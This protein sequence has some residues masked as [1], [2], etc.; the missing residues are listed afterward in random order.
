MQDIPELADA[1]PDELGTPYRYDGSI[2]KRFKQ[3]LGIG[4]RK[5]VGT[6]YGAQEWHIE[7][8]KE[9]HRKVALWRVVCGDAGT[10][11]DPDA[12]FQNSNESIL[13]PALETP[14]L[15]A[16]PAQTEKVR[17]TRDA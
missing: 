13:N 4:L 6:R 3:T 10:C 12:Q 11:G 9:G 7:S 17:R 2:D 8:M 15:P 5:R 1:L 14:A 16:V